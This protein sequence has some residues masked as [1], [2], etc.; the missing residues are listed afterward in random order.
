MMNYH[1]RKMQH[2]W[3]RPKTTSLLEALLISIP[4]ALI[5]GWLSALTNQ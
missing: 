1:W 2:A 3:K 5:L 4:I